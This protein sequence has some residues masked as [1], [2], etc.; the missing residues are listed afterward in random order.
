MR[1]DRGLALL[2]PVVAQLQAREDDHHAREPGTSTS[3]ATTTGVA[4]ADETGTSDGSGL[5]L[6]PRSHR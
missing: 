5:G 6:R 3:E 4:S 1:A 2:L